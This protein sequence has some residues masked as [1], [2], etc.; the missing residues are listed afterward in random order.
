MSSLRPSDWQAAQHFDERFIR[1]QS[2]SFL[3]Q[4]KQTI[5]VS[6]NRTLRTQ[7]LDSGVFLR[8]QYKILASYKDFCKLQFLFM[9]SFTHINVVFLFK[10]LPSK[11]SSW[12]RRLEDVL[13]A[14]FVFVFRRRLEDVLIKAN[15]FA[16][17]L[18]LQKT[19][20]RR[21]QD[22]FK[23]SCQDVFKTFSRRLQDVLQKRL[24]DIFKTSSRR[25]EDVFK[26]SSRRLEK[27]L[28]DIFKTSS[29][30]IIKLNCSC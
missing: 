9:Y 23:T 28:Q 3:S 27:R 14:S 19:S 6:R 18:R 10:P 21:L 12:W 24:Q 2:G 22:V 17:A 5:W 11:N 8:K 16:L 13:K 26:T 4:P 30:R 7:Y 1:K 29:R 25:F 15:M 20:S